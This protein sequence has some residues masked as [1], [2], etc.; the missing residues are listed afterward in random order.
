MSCLWN[1]YSYCNMY[2]IMAPNISG[3]CRN[4]SVRH[5]QNL[6]NSSLN[7]LREVLQVRIQHEEHGLLALIGGRLQLRPEAPHL[8]STFK[9]LRSV[10]FSELFCL[11]WSFT[12]IEAMM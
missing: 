7:T 8:H 10:E 9:I 6:P 5:L 12:S 3:C 4:R 1:I 2:R 11:A